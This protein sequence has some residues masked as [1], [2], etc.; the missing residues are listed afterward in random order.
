[1]CPGSHI[2]RAWG[3]TPSRESPDVQVPAARPR[4]GRGRLVQG[5]SNARGRSIKRTLQRRYGVHQELPLGALKANCGI[6]S[7]E[8]LGRRRRPAPAGKESDVCTRR[9]PRRMGGGTERRIDVA[10]RGRSPRQPTPDRMAKTRRITANTGSRRKAWRLAA[11][12]VVAMTA[13]TTQPRPS[14]GPLGKR[15]RRCQERPGVVPVMGYHAPGHS[16]VQAACLTAMSCGGGEGGRPTPRAATTFGLVGEPVLAVLQGNAAADRRS[17]AAGLGKTQRPVDRGAGGN[18]RQSALPCGARRLPPTR[19]MTGYFHNHR[20]N[21]ERPSA[22][23]TTMFFA[24][25]PAWPVRTARP[26]AE[27]RAAR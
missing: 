3:A 21:P 15:G 16:A 8:P 17:L 19:H 25:R 13:R 14:Q 18:R 2:R 10:K 22:R 4:S 6:G 27:I 26:V 24:R 12:A 9:A 5:A 11:E 23:P 1:M 20:Q 7:A